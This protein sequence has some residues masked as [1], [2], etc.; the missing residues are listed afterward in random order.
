MNAPAPMTLIARLG[1]GI[2]S[3]GRQGAVSAIING[4]ASALDLISFSII[5]RIL[6]AEHLGI[7]LVALSVGTIV[8]RVG[9]PNF[10]QTF[11][12]HTVRAVETQRASDLRLILELAVLF[13]FG[14]LS[15]R[16]RKRPRH[17]RTGCPFG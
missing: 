17:R 6:S 15:A 16:M 9:S 5:A 8:E 13:D 12:R 2:G 4:I 3:A 14:L 10:A 1:K 7:F 11:M